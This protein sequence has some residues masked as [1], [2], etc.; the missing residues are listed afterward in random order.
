[1]EEVTKGPITENTEEQKELNQKAQESQECEKTAEQK[2][3]ETPTASKK[4]ELRKEVDSIAIPE[5]LTSKVWNI[6]K[7]PI[8]ELLVFNGRIN[9]ERA[10][11]LIDGGASGSF[12]A[13]AFSK[14]LGLKSYPLKKTAELPDG[15][16][17]TMRSPKESIKIQMQD[18]EEELQPFII[19]LE[20]YDLILGNSWLRDWNPLIDWKQNTGKVLLSREASTS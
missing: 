10:T 17:L 14:K 4:K 1:M 18:Y 12:L 9:G 2:I 16:F 6:S 8:S 19:D 15:S 3:K 20:G 13:N 5:H 7:E 11:I